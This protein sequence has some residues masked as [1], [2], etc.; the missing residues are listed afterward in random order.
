MARHDKCR[1]ANKFLYAESALI[2]PHGKERV[3][4][5]QKVGVD[6]S[7]KENNFLDVKNRLYRSQ[8]R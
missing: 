1:C 7:R 6:K 5:K 3:I 2:M 4:L 8:M